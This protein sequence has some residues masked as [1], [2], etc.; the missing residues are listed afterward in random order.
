[1]LLF[2]G[3]NVLGEGYIVVLVKLLEYLGVFFRMVGTNK[4]F[5]VFQIRL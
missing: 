2:D 5:E 3:S 4:G 1:M